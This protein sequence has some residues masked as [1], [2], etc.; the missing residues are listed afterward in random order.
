[1]ASYDKRQLGHVDTHVDT[2]AHNR[3]CDFLACVMRFI[4][5][6]TPSLQNCAGMFAELCR[7]DNGLFCWC[8]VAG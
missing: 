6:E 7:S 2:P 1:M 5:S 4:M 8:M 3:R